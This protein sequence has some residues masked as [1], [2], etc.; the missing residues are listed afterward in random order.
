MYICEYE[1]WNKVCFWMMNISLNFGVAKNCSCLPPSVCLGVSESLSLSGDESVL[2]GCNWHAAV[3][4]VW[5]PRYPQ[6]KIWWAFPRDRRVGARGSTSP[7]YKAGRGCSNLNCWI[8]YLYLL[9][10][11][12]WWHCNNPNSESIISKDLARTFLQVPVLDT[13]ITG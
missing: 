10:I 7:E 6:W 9:R 1:V 13:R 3:R 8:L 2:T 5:F 4:L 12:C 11:C